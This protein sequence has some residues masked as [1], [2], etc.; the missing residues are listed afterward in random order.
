MPEKFKVWVSVEREVEEP[1]E[2]C[3]E[4]EDVGEPELLGELSSEEAAHDF[5]AR[6]SEVK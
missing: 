4:F 6:L 1:P 2:D 3:P 5:V